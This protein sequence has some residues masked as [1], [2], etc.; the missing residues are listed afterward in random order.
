M[1]RGLNGKWIGM[2]EAGDDRMEI[3]NKKIIYIYIYLYI[4]IINIYK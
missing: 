3:N 4:S 1:A 2:V